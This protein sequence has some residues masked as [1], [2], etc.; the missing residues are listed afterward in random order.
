MPTPPKSALHLD[1]ID[2]VTV[3]SFAQSR[4]VDEVLIQELGDAFD[5]LVA[6]QG[7]MRLLLNF[8]N[9][10]YLSSAMLG[11]LVALRA[12]LIAAKGSLV[13]CSIKGELM[14]PFEASGLDKVFKI[15]KDEQSALKAF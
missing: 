5:R 7:L 11:K 1:T 2:G 12:R 15:C 10:E 13:L 4:I 3:V 8:G 14:I 9:V 6:E